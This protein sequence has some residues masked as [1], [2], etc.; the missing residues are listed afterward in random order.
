MYCDMLLSWKTNI[1]KRADSPKQTEPSVT[2]EWTPEEEL[3]LWEIKQF[4]EKLARQRAA[5]Q[6]KSGSETTTI[7]QTTSV[8][9][10][11]LKAQLEQQLKQQR[12]ALQQKRLLEAQGKIVTMATTAPSL[13]SATLNSAAGGTVI[14]TLGG[15]VGSSLLTGGTSILKTVQPKTLSALTG[16]ATTSGGTPIRPV[17]KV[18]LPMRTNLQTSSGVTLAPKPG[19]IVVTTAQPSAVTRLIVPISKPQLT[20]TKVNV[21][22]NPALQTTPTRVIVPSSI[23]TPSPAVPKVQIRPTS[24]PGTQNLQ[25]IQGPSGQLQVRGLLQGQQIIRLPI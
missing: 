1:G 20:P 3:E 25:I 18:Q 13:I 24:S 17:V 6:E 7:Q 10:A 21:I 5:I 14:K 2:E 15:T 22:G 11:Q 23:Q 9:A 16:V 8:N 4:G 19:S 12:L